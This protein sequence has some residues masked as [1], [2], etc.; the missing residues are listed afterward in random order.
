MATFMI[1]ILFAGFRIR[2]LGVERAG[3]MMLLETIVTITATMGGFGVGAAAVRRMSLYFGANQLDK[4][5]RPL[6][7]MLVVNGSIGLLA[8][9]AYP[10]CF[11]A[12]FGWSQL[13]TAFRTDAFCAALLI[14]ATFFCRQLHRSYWHTLPALQRFD[15]MAVIRTVKSL[16]SGGLGLLVLTWIPTMTALATVYL[17]I[18]IASLVVNMVLIRRFLGYWVLPAWCGDEMRAMLQFGAWSYAGSLSRLL[19]NGLDRIIVTAVLGSA[20]L[21]YYVIG[22]RII[23]RVHTVLA[24]QYEFIF[25]MLSAESERHAQVIERVEDRL[26]WMVA[27]MSAILYA[28]LAVYSR[29]LL[30]VLVS[31]E[32]A[33][34]AYIPF[35]LACAQ[36]FFLA[37]NLTVYRISWAE[38][39]AAPNAIYEFINGILVFVTVLILVPSMGVVG[40]SLAQMWYGI[41]TLGFIVW[42]LQSGHRFSWHRL[43]RPFISPMLSMG[44]W[45][46]LNRFLTW[47]FELSSVTRLLIQTS[48]GLGFVALGLLYEAIHYRDYRCV[49]S[50]LD[51]CRTLKHFIVSKTVKRTRL[52]SPSG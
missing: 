49:S 4:I 15:V 47:Q 33:Q 31:P 29:S 52:V 19:K 10:A 6:G 20:A 37:Q 39:K 11:S 24:G 25:P 2:I 32:F 9:L 44:G 8:F 22:Q 5:R 35:V 36:G 16:L 13:D 27:F 38:G 48:T 1:S 30:S 23:T 3:F 43:F 26:R 14:G 42:V 18:A 7:T 21:P 17:G 34:E 40:A 41:T 45:V 46:V 50:L 28:T 51:A 12:L